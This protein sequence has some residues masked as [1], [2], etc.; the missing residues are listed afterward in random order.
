MINR[1]MIA[2]VIVAGAL[3]PLQATALDLPKGKVVLTVTGTKLDHPNV[4]GKAQFDMP[5]LEALAGRTGEM[6]TPWTQGVVKFS[7]PLLRSVLEAAG[8]HGN[9]LKVIALNDYAADLPMED[10]TSLDTMLATRMDGKLM[11]VRDKGP[12]F[13]VYPFDK[14][15]GLF[16]E[17]YFSR[18]VWQIKDIEVTE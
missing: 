12:L 13:L 14:D 18:S 8:A 5:M 11:S 17:K 16:N 10:A 4:G 9:K 15:Q 3:L 1:I 6:E 2:A 7:G